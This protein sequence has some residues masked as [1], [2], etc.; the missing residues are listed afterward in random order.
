MASPGQ[1]AA[2]LTTKSKREKAVKA[3]AR[4][5]TWEQVAAEAGYSGPAA[6]YKAV[7]EYFRNYP[8]PDAE[9]LRDVENMKLDYMEQKVHDYLD[10]PHVVISSSG[11]VATRRVGIL[12][13]SEGQPIFDPKGRAVYA[14][15]E[16]EDLEPMLRGVTT[17]LNISARRAKLNGLDTLVVKAEIDNGE[18]DKEIEDLVAGM[19]AAG[20]P[21]VPERSNE[22]VV[23]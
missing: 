6:A 8:H 15:E 18:V 22:S 5:R 23:Q 14:T 3:R 1:T 7:Q 2:A 20:E 19:I 9:E 12:T 17:L 11:V 4:G 10:Q 13:D 16:V 21:K